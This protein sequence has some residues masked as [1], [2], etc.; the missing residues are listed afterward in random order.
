VQW[1]DPAAFASVPEAALLP[2]L[3]PVGRDGLARL[4]AE[5]DRVLHW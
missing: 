5:Y 1:I 2:G 3:K 4:F